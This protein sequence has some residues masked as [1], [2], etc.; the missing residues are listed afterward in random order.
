M[1]SSKLTTT[2]TVPAAQH[3]LAKSLRPFA[4]AA[5]PEK[6]PAKATAMSARRNALSVKKTRILGALAIDK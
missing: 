6:S 1:E 5:A 2:G 4:Q 3:Q